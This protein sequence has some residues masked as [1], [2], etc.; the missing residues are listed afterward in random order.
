VYERNG[1]PFTEIQ[2]VESSDLAP[3]DF[4]GWNIEMDAN[5]LI[6]GAPW[7]DEDA[8]GGNPI[9]RAGSAYIFKNP[10]LSTNNFSQPTAVIYPMPT[11]SH[12]TIAATAV[13]DNLTIVNQLGATLMEKKAI[14]ASQHTLNLSQ[15]AKGIYFLKIGMASGQSIVKKIIVD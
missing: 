3:E 15:Y 4:Y 8:N 12:L 10:L 5:Q 7:E 9:D 11:N 14:A 13:I 2:K 6:V 1:G